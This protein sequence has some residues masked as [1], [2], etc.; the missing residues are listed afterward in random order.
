MAIENQCRAVVAAQLSTEQR[1]G[2][3]LLT[4]GDSPARTALVESE[5]HAGVETLDAGAAEPGIR[6][7]MLQGAGGH[8]CAG[9]NLV[10]LMVRRRR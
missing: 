1:G 6:S 4:P 5:L 8:F 7:V 3:L 9:G 2:N 10:G